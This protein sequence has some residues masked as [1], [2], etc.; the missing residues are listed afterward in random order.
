[1]IFDLMQSRSQITV[2][3]IMPAHNV[4][5]YIGEAIGSVLG[6]HGA[7]FELLIL[8]DAS[9]DGTWGQIQACTNDS[10]TRVWRFRKQKGAGAARNYLIARARGRYLAFCDADD[11]LLPG[12]LQKMV[13]ALNQNPRVG[14]AYTD[15]LVEVRP[16][17]FKRGR[18]SR[19]P[20]ETWDLLDGT[21]SNGGTIVRRALVRKAGGYRKD[22]PCLEDY[23]L[24]WRLRAITRFVY[25]KGKPLYVYRQRPGSMTVQFKNK[26]RSIRLRLLRQVILQR[27]GFRVRWPAKISP[28]HKRNLGKWAGW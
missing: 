9:K 25:L 2:S 7:A 21:I 8:D 20:A 18:R 3:V 11:K 27:Y 26:S 28:V 4:E 16:G 15:R 10:R 24:F 1:L 19:G 5:K 22:L 6:Q 17:K 14:V 13:R 23:E 12:F